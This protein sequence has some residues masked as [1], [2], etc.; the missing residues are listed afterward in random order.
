MFDPWDLFTQSHEEGIV[1]A[2]TKLLQP[3]PADVRRRVALPVTE[4]RQERRW[5]RAELARRAK[6][7]CT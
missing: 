7:S 6:I 3:A 5:T 1:S 4:L 2:R